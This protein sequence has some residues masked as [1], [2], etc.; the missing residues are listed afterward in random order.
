MSR[1]FIAAAVHDAALPVAFD[2]TALVVSMQNV[3]DGLVIN[4]PNNT[5]L[6]LTERL[7]NEMGAFATLKNTTA[8]IV[9]PKIQSIVAEYNATVVP[10]RIKEVVK[11]Y[12]AP[13]WQGAQDAAISYAENHELNKAKFS[14]A[15]AA[16]DPV[17]EQAFRDELRALPSKAEKIRALNNWQIE[18]AFAVSRLGH[19]A[20]GLSAE[21]FEQIV[22]NRIRAH[23]LTNSNAL[24][25][26]FTKE[27]TLNDPIA[28]GVDNIKI[29]A[30]VQDAIATWKKRDAFVIDARTELQHMVLFA[31][32]VTDTSPEAAFDLLAGNNE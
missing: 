28:R 23:N 13:V 8:T 14:T 15:P 2:N 24:R 9:I 18:V 32:I 1:L 17:V 30:Y 16:T 26:T 20:F 19:Q 27:P 10:P 4:A 22:I 6:I 21:E 11:N 3:H 7:A 29:A 12:L 5:N 25:T 31:S